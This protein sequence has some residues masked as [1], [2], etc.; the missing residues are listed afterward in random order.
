MAGYANPSRTPGLGLVDGWLATSDLACLDPDGALRIL[1]RAD[2]VLVTGGVNVHPARVESVLLEAP[3]VRDL[4]VVGVSDPIWGQRLVAVYCGDISPTDLDAWCRSR[5]PGTERPRGFLPV[6]EI[7]L[8]ES[9][10]RD[11]RRLLEIAR[12]IGEQHR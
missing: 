10:K 7:P 6:P 4:A 8:L 12:R 3:G 1:G 11:R 9:G 2:E 5:L